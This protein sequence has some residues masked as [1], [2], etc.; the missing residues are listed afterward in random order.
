MRALWEPLWRRTNSSHAA[1]AAHESHSQAMVFMMQWGSATKRS[2]FRPVRLNDLPTGLPCF[3]VGNISRPDPIHYFEGWFALGRV[4]QGEPMTEFF[5]Q[6]M[7]CPSS[8]VSFL[9]RN[10]NKRAVP[11][12]LFCQL[13][14]VTIS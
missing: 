1:F 5:A 11:K 13:L 6:F 9:M 7:S 14:V 4:I 2:L 12:V 10:F 8:G 3:C